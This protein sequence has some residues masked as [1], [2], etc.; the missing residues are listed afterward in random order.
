MLLFIY[1]TQKEMRYDRRL[2]LYPHSTPDV[3]GVGSTWNSCGFCDVVGF[4]THANRL[5]G[6]RRYESERALVYEAWLTA[7]AVKLKEV[8]TV[9][10]MRRID[11]A[12]KMINWFEKRYDIEWEDALKEI[13]KGMR[14]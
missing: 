2:R 4:M 12:D 6:T 8:K 14:R 11:D 9:D 10:D 7:S 13:A 1:T 5:I 3:L